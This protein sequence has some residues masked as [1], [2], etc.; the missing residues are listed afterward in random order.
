[1]TRRPVASKERQREFAKKMASDF[2]AAPLHN[3]VHDRLSEDD[4]LARLCDAAATAD[5]AGDLRESYHGDGAELVEDV[6]DAWGKLAHVARKRALEVVAES[7]RTVIKDGDQWAAAGYWEREKVVDA[8]H[9]AADWLQYHTT[10]AERADV[11]E[12]VAADV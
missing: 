7:C 6:R 8:R 9:E 10:D 4:Q 2:D 5:A 11:L 1:M 12:E 3:K